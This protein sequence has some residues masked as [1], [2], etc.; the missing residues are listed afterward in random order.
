MN[1]DDVWGLNMET[2]Y[3]YDWRADQQKHDDDEQTRAVAE[4]FER[5]YLAISRM[6]MMDNCEYTSLRSDVRLT[7]MASWRK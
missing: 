1:Q 7:E 5:I 2:E 4:A 3:D 6:E